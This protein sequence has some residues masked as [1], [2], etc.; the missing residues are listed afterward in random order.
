MLVSWGSL[1]YAAVI[2]LVI[3]LVSC[4]SLSY[5]AVIILVIILVSCG[6]LLCGSHHSG[7]C[8][9]FMR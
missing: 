2:I 9:T 7:Y 4:G 8:A 1:C 3:I 6:S 5:V